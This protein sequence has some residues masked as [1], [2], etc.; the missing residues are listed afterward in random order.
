MNDM[1]VSKALKWI[2]IAQILCLLAFIPVVGA[3]LSIIAL[4]LELVA[5]Y[6]ASKLDQGYHTAFILT[7][8]GIVLSVLSLFAGDGVFASLVSIVSDVVSLGILYFVITTT[9]K[10][11]EEVGNAEVAK[12]GMNVWRINLVCTIACV[13]LILLAFVPVLAV[14][15]GVVVAIVQIVA[16][17]LYLIFLYKSY[18][19]L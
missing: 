12:K 17:I 19:A 4:V 5:L 10:H 3:I 8:V 15:L 16:Y 7:I 11:L 9:C 1:T 14:L 13:V 2:F 18:Q 6:G